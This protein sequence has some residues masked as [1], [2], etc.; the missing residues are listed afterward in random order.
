MVLRHYRFSITFDETPGSEYIINDMSGYFA[1]NTVTR[2][3]SK[4]C[5]GAVKHDGVV[6]QQLYPPS[7]QVG[8]TTSNNL[9]GSTNTSTTFTTSPLNSGSPTTYSNITSPP[10]FEF[11]ELILAN[12]FITIY[13]SDNDGNNVAQ[14]WRLTSTS[15][16]EISLSFVQGVGL[17]DTWDPID[18]S[19]AAY[20]ITFTQVSGD[21]PTPPACFIEGS[22]IYSHVNGKDIYLPIQT[23]KKGD[24]VKTYL[25][26]YRKIIMIGKNTM[27]NDPKRWN[28]SVMR[29]PKDKLGAIEDLMITGAHSVLVDNLSEKEKD[30]QIAIYNTID[31]KIDGKYLLL[32]S[33]SEN[34]EV[35]DD[36]DSYTYYHFVLEHDGDVNVRYGVWANGVL[37]ESQPE[38]HFLSKQYNLV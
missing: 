1:Y 17:T 5:N 24:L 13:Y 19:I 20:S 10:N 37:T 33:V 4:M 7:K 15:G 25:H 21:N 34:F 9:L 35:V 6:T 31:R 2:V 3:I 11:G 23:L 38:K 12:S 16:N 30:G 32:A 36:N 8:G 27:T 29:L 28:Y 18:D 22:K 26:G 14:Y